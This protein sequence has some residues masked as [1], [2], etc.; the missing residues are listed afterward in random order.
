MTYIQKLSDRDN[1]IFDAIS[2]ILVNMGNM[3]GKQ[4]RWE[5]F[6]RG[7]FIQPKLLEQAVAVMK[8]KK[9]ITKPEAKPET[10]AEPIQEKKEAGVQ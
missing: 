8:E 9:L 4:L 5:L 3:N 7:I 2:I 10:N 1:L 6:N